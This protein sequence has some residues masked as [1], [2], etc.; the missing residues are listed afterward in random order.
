M[1]SN[2]PNTIGFTSSINTTVPNNTVNVARLLANG[3]STDMDAVFS[4]KGI[5][6]ILAH[7]PDGTATGGNKR[8]TRTVD[9]Q[10]GRT[11]NSKVAANDFGFLGGG[12]NNSLSLGTSDYASI[13]GGNSNTIGSNGLGSFIGGGETNTVNGARSVICGGTNNVTASNAQN[14]CIVGGSS[15]QTTQS[16]SSVTGG[17]YAIANAYGKQAYASGRFSDN[18]DCQSGIQILRG[19]VTSTTPVILTANASTAGTINQIQLQN[20]QTMLVTCYVTARQTITGNSKSVKI[21]AVL[22]RGATASTTTVSTPIIETILQDSGTENWTMVL[23]ADTTNGCGAI[24]FTVDST[25]NVR[26]MAKVETIELTY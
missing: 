22:K 9:L 16:Y 4:P 21:T 3:A 20:N 17:F 18:G 5:G 11:A 23:T 1:P 24:T 15:N 2:A 6:S 26:C 7:A 10:T 19:A 8:G 12:Y 25:I 14:S 13:V